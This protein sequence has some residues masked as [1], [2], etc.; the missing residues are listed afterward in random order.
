MR[1]YRNDRGGL[2]RQCA[3]A[4]NGALACDDWSLW[5][6]QPAVVRVNGGGDLQ[7]SKPMVVVVVFAHVGGGP[8]HVSFG[9]V[10]VFCTGK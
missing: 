4:G 5:W 7:W 8:T 2:G 1:L 9:F 6:R 3:R 10:D